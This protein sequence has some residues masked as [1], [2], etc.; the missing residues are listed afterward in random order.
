MLD[1]CDGAHSVAAPL[2]DACLGAI[3]TDRPHQT[4]TP[5]VVPAGHAQFESALAAVRLGG[6]APRPRLVLLE[7]AYKLGVVSGFDLELFFK[8]AEYV[9]ADRQWLPPGPF[10]VRAK[11]VLAEERGWVPAITFVPW[12]VVPMAPEQSLGGGPFVFWGWEL[13]LGFELEVNAGVFFRRAPEPKVAPVLASALTFAV[14][15]RFRVFVDVYATGPDVAFGTGALW[16]FTR[17]MQID[18]G[19]YAGVRGNEPD[20]TPFVGFSIRQ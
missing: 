7:N 18:F 6:N 4:D 12:V 3:D 1:A 5:H 14:V 2:P 9:P 15:G 20:A 16:A 13:P 8:H 11:I 17:D 19:T 10:A